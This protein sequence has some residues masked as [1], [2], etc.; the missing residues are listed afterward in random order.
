LT[1]LER[2]DSVSDAWFNRAL[3]F[4]QEGNLGRALELFAACC[5][6]RPSDASALRALAKVW[7]HL[8][9]FDEAQDALQ[10]AAAIDPDAPEL[11]EI[12]RALLGLGGPTR[13]R[14]LARERRPRPRRK[15]T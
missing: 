13:R 4:L 14:R 12:R 2:L 11:G 9:R 5:A 6:A 8:G 15:R 1:L 3:E 7:G 10:R